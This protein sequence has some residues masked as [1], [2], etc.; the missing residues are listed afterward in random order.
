[1]LFV[2]LLAWAVGYNAARR[3]E[4]QRAARRLAQRQAVAD[5]RARIARE[6]HDLIGHTVNVMLV[7][8]GAA[9]RVL[10]REPAKTRELIAGVEQAGREALTEL[11]RVLGV[12]RTDGESPHGLAD[13]PEL[14][15]RMTAAGLRVE[16]R[17]EVSDLPRS[18]DL[19]AYRIIQES[20]TNTLK[21]GA[22]ASVSVVLRCDGDVLTVEI[23]DD[24]RG[25]PADYAP[26]RGLLGIAERVAL[27]GG[28]VEH[29]TGD[30]F[31]VLAR[32]P[33]PQRRAE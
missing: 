17:I 1:V 20:L 18:L 33:L 8:A 21:H 11:D 15:A 23:K 9:R 10:D 7:Q 12:L 2:W 25:A 26:G 32:L 27:F 19:T 16:T 6:L 24:G 29:G 3:R 14:A 4:E 30:G 5:E 13:V 31:H 22:A 28:S